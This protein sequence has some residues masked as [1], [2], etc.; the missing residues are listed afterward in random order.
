MTV[1]PAFSVIAALKAAFGFVPTGIARAWLSLGLLLIVFGLYQSGAV[2][3]AAHPVLLLAS[4]GLQFAAIGALYRVAIFGTYA[5]AEGLGFG[6]LQFARTEWRLIGAT[7]LV[8]LFWLMVF[9]TLS[10]VL[11][12]IMSASGMGTETYNSPA[13]LFQELKGGQVAGLVIMALI[14]LILCVLGVLSLKLSLYQPAT[15][16]GRQMISLNALN[17]S[18]GQVIKLLLGYGV[19]CLPLIILAYGL[20]GLGDHWSGRLIDAA[21][22]VLFVLPVTVGFLS[23]AYKQI[24]DLRASH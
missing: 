10:L 16:A 19:I 18:S 23:S 8:G 20:Q 15:V 17:L 5:R 9:I 2:P 13:G 21:I 14:V 3:Q 1:K 4:V 24:M 11:A 12:V 7:L 22:G 6:G